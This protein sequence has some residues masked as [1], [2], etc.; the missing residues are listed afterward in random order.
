MVDQNGVAKGLKK[1]LEERYNGFT[2]TNKDVK[3]NY[4]QVMAQFSDFKNEKTLVE[5]ELESQKHLYFYP[6]S[7]L[8]FSPIEILKT[9]MGKHCVAKKYSTWNKINMLRI[10]QTILGES[11]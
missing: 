8:E 2:L 6:K 11:S 10:S 5:N 7:H 3:K 4:R 9:K 1:V